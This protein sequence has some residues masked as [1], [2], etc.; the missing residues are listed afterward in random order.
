MINKVSVYFER[1][2]EILFYNFIIKG[3]EIKMAK[4]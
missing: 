1:K 4:K 3:V 2:I